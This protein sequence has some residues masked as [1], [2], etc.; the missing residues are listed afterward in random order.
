MDMT[1]APK[2]RLGRGLAALI[3][4]DTSEEAVVQDVRSLRQMP[5]ELLRASPNNPRKHFAEAGS[6]RTRQF[7]PRQGPAAADRGAPGGRGRI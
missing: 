1:G 2:K 6:R 3:G 4:D 7:D 5:I